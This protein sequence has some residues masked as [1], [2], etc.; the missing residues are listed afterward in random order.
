MTRPARRIA[1]AAALGL[2]LIGP[3]LTTAPARAE[4]FDLKA[5][6]PDQKTAFGAAVRDYLMEH[7]EVLVEAI[8]KLQAQQAQQQAADD[9]SLI[10]ANAKAIYEDPNSW[11]GGNPQG[12]VTLVEFMDYRCG[13]CR[14]ALPEVAKLLKTDGNI[15]YIVKEFPILTD[16]SVLGARYAIAL[17]K[18]AGDGAYEKAHNALM[19]LRGPINEASLK[20]LS[21]KIGVDFATIQP[22]MNS[23]Y[24]DKVISENHALAGRL[25]INGTPTFV[26]GGDLLRGYVPFDQL[27]QF[28]TDTRQAEKG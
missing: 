18:V 4:G 23:A 10:K 12:D 11:V 16:Q 15:R 27:Q 3:A 9:A 24:V 8:N 26:L 21:D 19:L 5:M 28:V 22:E 7:P 6:T 2:G 25:K 14:K 20:E 13:Y 1:L 17:R